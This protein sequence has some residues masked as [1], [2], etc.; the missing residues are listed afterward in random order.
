MHVNEPGFVVCLKTQDL[1]NTKILLVINS[2]RKYYVL[3][4]VLFFNYIFYWSIVDLQCCVSFRCTAKWI[5][6]T[7][8]YIHSFYRLFSRI[9]H[10]RVLSRVPCAIQQVLISYLFYIQQCLY[11]TPNLLIYPSPRPFSF[12]NHKFVF[13]DCESVS[14]L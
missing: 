1:Q 12:G 6:Y 4:F 10:Y 7:Y 2:S 3:I 13:E 9:D 14:V 11:V 5:S 8:T